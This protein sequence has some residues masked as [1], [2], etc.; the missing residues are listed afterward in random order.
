M[1]SSSAD[2]TRGTYLAYP[3]CIGGARSWPPEDC[4]GT[5]GYAELR[6]AL[7]D[8]EHDEHASMKTWVGKTGRGWEDHIASGPG[9]NSRVHSLDA[10]FETRQAPTA[11]SGSAAGR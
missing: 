5:S 4:G 8:P 6:E 2:V 9:L 1:K 7:A 10:W 3:I 11:T